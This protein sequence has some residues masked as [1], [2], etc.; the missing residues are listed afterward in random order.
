MF[1][2]LA[3]ALLVSAGSLA[4]QRLYYQ[5]SQP[6]PLTVAAGEGR[7]I[8]LLTPDNKEVARATVPDG[9]GEVDAASLI[10][11]LYSFTTVHYLQLADDGEP[12]GPALVLQPLI[13]V[14]NP[15]L[16]YT[17]RGPSVENWIDQPERDKNMAG[18]RVY[19]ERDAV[20]H[21]THGDIRL[22]MRPEHAPNTVWNFLH[23]VEGG[24]YTHIPF[25][26]VVG[27]SSGGPGF[28]IQAGD[29]TG[30]GS[31]GP[32]YRI[33]LEASTLPHDLGVISMA[34]EGN[35]IHTAG[36]QFFLCLSREATSRLD[37][38]YTTFGQT[39]E[40]IDVIKKIGAVRVGSQDRPIDMPY[41]TTAELVPAQPRT[42][43]QAPKWITPTPAAPAEK[44][45][46]PANP[47]R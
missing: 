36:S 37:G 24:F 17:E 12:V 2:A 45:A 40:G 22:V 26:R 20:L 3:A 34:R 6:M 41:I 1:H 19:I 42:P 47:P 46:A 43:G 5:I 31:G 27:T 21:T 32:G 23:L 35:D 28:V 15:V 44:P 39:I 7:E 10:P 33:D 8:V 30:T 29:P 9:V 16:R 4:P 14:R 38:Q 13:R 11:N 25:H 18:F